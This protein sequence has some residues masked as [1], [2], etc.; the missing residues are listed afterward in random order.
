MDPIPGMTDAQLWE[1]AEARAAELVELLRP[2]A[3]EQPRYRQ[4]YW[5]LV[6][7]TVGALATVTRALAARRSAAEPHEDNQHVE[8]D[9]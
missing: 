8:H 2:A 7:N 9:E 5:F 1:E 3:R 6:G 4:R